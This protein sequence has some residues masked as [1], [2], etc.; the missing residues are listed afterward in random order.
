MNLDAPYWNRTR[1]E[2]I[3]SSLPSPGCRKASEYKYN[4]KT[5]RA[6]LK[7]KGKKQSIAS[8]K[9]RRGTPKSAKL[10]NQQLK[11]D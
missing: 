11:A 8:G 2:R 5:N 10:Q 1:L 9:F 7:K 4:A 6:T 3:A